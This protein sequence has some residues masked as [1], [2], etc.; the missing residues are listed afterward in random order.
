VPLRTHPALANQRVQTRVGG[1]VVLSTKTSWRD[2]AT[3]LVMPPMACMQP[4]IDGQLC[5]IERCERFVC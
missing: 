3:H 2:S 4:P 1:Q 5:S